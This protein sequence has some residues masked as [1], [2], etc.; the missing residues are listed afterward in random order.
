MI[1]KKC[2]VCDNDFKTYNTKSRFCTQKCY[3]IWRKGLTYEEFLGEKRGKKL[4]EKQSEHFKKLKEERIS[5]GLPVTIH[6]FPK[7]HKLRSGCT[8][9]NKDKTGLQTNK[10]KGLVL[11]DYYD[12]ETYDRIIEGC[13]RGGVS[14]CLKMASSKNRTSIELKVEK[15]LKEIGERYFSQY[16]LLG[17]T[18]SDFYLP[19]K[20]IVIYCDGDY[21]HDYPNGTAHDHNINKELTTKSYK[22]LRFWERDIN[23]NPEEIKK[24]IIERFNDY[25]ASPE[26]GE[27]I[28]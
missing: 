11:K 9:W 1:E 7:G 21:W 6:P 18:V 15:I 23:K 19:D 26:M 12:K 25:N 28:V 5:K 20:R 2:I 27:C 16:A 14:C 24:Q 22:V 3:K 8:P 10:T 17:L 4:R 13:I